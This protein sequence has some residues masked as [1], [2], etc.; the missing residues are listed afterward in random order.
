V[1]RI[2]DIVYCDVAGQPVVIV[3]SL[4]AATALF[5]DK[6]ALYANRHHMHFSCDM[7]GWKDLMVMMRDGT[8]SRFKESRRLF[9]QALGTKTAIEKVIPIVENEVHKAI[10]RMIDEPKDSL[11]SNHVRR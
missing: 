4:A 10:R 11:I 8:G 5:E 3:N 6:S 1:N 2:G 9:A 7:I